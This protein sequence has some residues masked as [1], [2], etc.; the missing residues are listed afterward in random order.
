MGSVL[1]AEEGRLVMNLI[2]RSVGLLV[3]LAFPL[4]ARAESS[5]FDQPPKDYP[6]ILRAVFKG[7]TDRI[8]CVAVRH[9]GKL[10]ASGGADKTVRLWDVTTGKEQRVL[11][12]SNPVRGVAFSSDGKKLV[13]ADANKPVL[14]NVE[15]GEKLATLDEV[16]GPIIQVAFTADGKTVGAAGSRSGRLWDVKT[17]ME[18]LKFEGRFAFSPDGKTL[19]T[20]PVGGSIQLWDLRTGTKGITLEGH[21]GPVFALAFAPDGKTLA[22]GPFAGG[23]KGTGPDKSIKLWDVEKGNERASL[24][25]HLKGIY[26]LIFSPDGKMLLAADFNG[27]MK[28]WDVE[29]GRV[30]A[31]LGKVKSGDKLRGTPIGH[32]VIAPDLKTWVVGTGLEVQW[33]DISEFTGATKVRQ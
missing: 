29:K 16:P 31:T 18:K 15:T 1:I 5:Q 28:L 12:H 6:G 3:L 33:L 19:A 23:Q 11:R 24:V 30:K 13:T 22:S 7:H 21:K 10:V 27:S 26:Y 25:G 14:W 2:R 4:P 32:W 8:N 9:D 17:G 20:C